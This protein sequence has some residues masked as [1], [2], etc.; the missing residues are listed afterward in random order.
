MKRTMQTLTMLNALIAVVAASLLSLGASAALAQ[1]TPQT[2]DMTVTGTIVPAACSASFE[3]G[4]VV[5]FKTI[6]LVDLQDN[7]YAQIGIKD[8]ALTVTCSS[9]LFVSFNIVDLQ[10]GT[11]VSNAEIAQQ[12]GAPGNNPGYLFGLGMAT[13]GGVPQKLGAYSI[14]FVPGKFATVDGSDRFVMLGA[15][16]AWQRAAAYYPVPTGQ[17]FAADSGVGRSLI[18]PMRVTAALNKGSVLQVAQ[19]TQLNG[20]AVF[21]INYR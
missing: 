9:N 2:A 7:A 18:F 15:P 17:N 19:D 12:A 16:G 20:Q 13:V 8:T 10:A 1:Q 5:D 21:S 6:K 11:L 4:G 3:G 14:G